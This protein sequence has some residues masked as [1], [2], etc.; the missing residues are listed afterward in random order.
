MLVNNRQRLQNF[1]L[2]QTK[3]NNP[4]ISAKKTLAVIQSFLKVKEK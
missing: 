1:L 3:K 2:G 4:N